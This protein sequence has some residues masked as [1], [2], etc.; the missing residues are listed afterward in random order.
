MPASH[1][2]VVFGSINMDLVARAERFPKPGETI[3]GE[4]FFTAPGGKGANQA[5][6]AAR[7]GA[8][9]R[10]IGRVG[11]DA[12]GATLLEGLA[13]QGVEVSGVI[14]DEGSS[15]GVA[16][17]E[18][19]ASGENT[20]IVVPGAN[21]S[22]G[23]DDLARLEVALEGARVLL[24]QLEVPIWAVVEAA[25]LARGRGV[26]VILDPAPAQVLP[27]GLLELVDVI[28]P[29]ES[30]AAALVGFA[31]N[32]PGE[33]VRAAKLL[34]ERGAR[35]VL[36]KRGEH[37]L[38]WTDGQTEVF[39]PTF[40]VRALDTVA[41]GDAFNGGLAA[42]LA[43]GLEIGEAISWGLATSAISVTRV[44]AQPS[45]PNREEVLR[46]LEASSQTRPSGGDGSGLGVT[47]TLGERL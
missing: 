14:R 34:L 3:T 23:E 12:F 26:M 1:A 45:L 29:N 21:G 43:E 46:L 39:R 35:S 44:G 38:Y 36:V 40:T 25:R 2:V 32:D 13:S 4:Q 18:V 5:V 8:D 17:I 15:S 27:A 42:A 47:A 19:T 28:T 6:A 30:E 37:G 16:V 41:A 10:M 11:S 9:T 20:I 24:L 33:V 22:L 31:V 7:L